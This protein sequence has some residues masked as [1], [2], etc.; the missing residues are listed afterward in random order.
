MRTLALRLTG[1]VPPFD[2]LK[3]LISLDPALFLSEP[4]PHRCTIRNR[5][6]RSNASR[7]ARRE[8]RRAG[9]VAGLCPACV[10]FL[11]DCAYIDHHPQHHL[12]P[13]PKQIHSRS[14]H[15]LRPHRISIIRS[16]HQHLHAA[17]ARKMA[18]TSHPFH[19]EKQVP[20]RLHRPA[21]R[22]PTALSLRQ[23][24]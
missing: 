5:V 17:L 23:K 21:T 15:W 1:C 20:L 7:S 12:N 19:R 14:P 8:R 6:F 13:Q 10:Y 22:A 4:R 18:G 2:P 11:S 3:S 9:Q 24:T 16:S